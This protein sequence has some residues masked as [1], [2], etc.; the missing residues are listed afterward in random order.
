M[1]Q[2]GLRGLGVD[3]RRDQVGRSQCTQIVET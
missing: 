1:T 2:P 3:A